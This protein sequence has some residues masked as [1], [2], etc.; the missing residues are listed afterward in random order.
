MT[1]C[2][3]IR[4]LDLTNNLVRL[5]IKIVLKYLKNLIQI[6]ITCDG[7]HFLADYLTTHAEKSCLAK[8]NLSLN[9]IKQEGCKLLCKVMS[10]I[11]HVFVKPTRLS[12]TYNSVSFVKVNYPIE[13]S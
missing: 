8:I 10:S 13:K 4:E 3:K 12:L 6:Q 9:K 5:L 2:G 7:I 1:S 11:L